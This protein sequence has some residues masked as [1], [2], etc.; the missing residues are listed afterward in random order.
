MR[1]E[2]EAAH[3]L[4]DAPL[5]FEVRDARLLVRRSHG[6]VD[7]VFDAGLTRECCQALALRLFPLDAR[8][9][10]VLHGEDTPRAGQ[11]TAQRRL[12]IQIALDDID[13]LMSQRRGPLAFR[14]AC[15]TAQMESRALQRL[16][17]RSTLLPCHSGDENRSIV[18][19]GLSSF[20]VPI[21]SAELHPWLIRRGRGREP[22]TVRRTPAGRRRRSPPTVQPRTGPGE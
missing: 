8:F 15:Q 1:G 17:H 7:I 10:R 12:V 21:Y 2:T 18:S 20:A 11:R 16:R 4:L 13:S 14:L 3:G 9:A 5:V 19:H 6:C 22:G